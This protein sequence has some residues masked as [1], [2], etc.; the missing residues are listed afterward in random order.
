MPFNCIEVQTS[1]VVGHFLWRER[2]K[3]SSQP[4]V[5]A[6]IEDRNFWR[7]CD[8]TEEEF[9]KLETQT[10]PHTLLKDTTLEHIGGNMRDVVLERQAHIQA[11]RVFPVPIT[12]AD[13]GQLPERSSYLIDGVHDSVALKRAFEK[14]GYK[15]VT[16]YI[17][18]RR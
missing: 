13:E 3:P 14:M 9:Y 5:R 6:Q 8:L 1:E 10:A 7:K 18:Q 11:S 4:G 12:L 2:S 16:I 17:G 15:P